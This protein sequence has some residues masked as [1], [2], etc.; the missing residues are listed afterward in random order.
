MCPVN[1]Q[2]GFYKKIRRQEMA[3]SSSFT[4]PVEPKLKLQELFRDVQ[5]YEFLPQWN[6]IFYMCVKGSLLILN[7]TYIYNIL[8]DMIKALLG[9]SL[10]N[11]FPY[12]CMT[13]MMSPVL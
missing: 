4:R 1:L 6:N 3:T 2:S 12:Y 5:T 13:T 9:N 11:S 8:T 7:K 10:V